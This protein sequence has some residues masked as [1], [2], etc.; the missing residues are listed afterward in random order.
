MSKTSQYIGYFLNLV[1]LFFIVAIGSALFSLGER[2]PSIPLPAGAR[3]GLEVIFYV[4]ILFFFYSDRKFDI[5]IWIRSLLLFLILRIFQSLSCCIV[6][7]VIAG[8]SITFANAFRSALYEHSILHII[9]F[10]SIPFLAFPIIFGYARAQ[11]EKEIEEFSQYIE[12]EELG[13]KAPLPLDMEEQI[14]PIRIWK[15]FFQTESVE[16][17][18]AL[19]TGIKLSDYLKNIVAPEEEE[20]QTVSDISDL[21]KELIPT[22]VGQVAL[23]EVAKSST[24][25]SEVSGTQPPETGVEIPTT[26]PTST[27]SPP[28]V[29]GTS[30]PAVS[31][32]SEL[33]QLLNVAESSG[34]SESIEDRGKTEAIPVGM[35]IETVPQEAVEPTEQIL[36]DSIHF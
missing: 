33:E 15:E 16:D 6:I 25:A 12:E 26:A 18:K 13:Q 8:D 7:K 11:T 9:Q 34:I 24:Q 31:E 17:V 28:T 27:I 4:L 2:I 5:D 3:L 35:P 22:E 23:S 20:I 14:I 32:L 1:L 19:L 10:L 30:M 29:E 21:L 36:I